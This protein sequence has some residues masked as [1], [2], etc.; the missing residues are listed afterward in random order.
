MPFWGLWK[1]TQGVRRNKV[2]EKNIY[3]CIIPVGTY[4]GKVKDSGRAFGLLFCWQRAP[5]IMPR[6]IAF[7]SI[8]EAV[9]PRVAIQKRR[10]FQTSIYCSCIHAIYSVF[11]NSFIEMLAYNHAIS[12]S[13]AS[14]F[15]FFGGWRRSEGSSNYKVRYLAR[16]IFYAF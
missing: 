16:N 15:A 8:V 2:Y 7:F 5:H 9:P 13:Q 14:C 12:S 6:S 3:R 10:L 4:S 1:P 11:C